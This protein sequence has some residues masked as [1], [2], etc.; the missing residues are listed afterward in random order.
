MR[1][2]RGRRG[3]PYLFLALLMAISMI[4]SSGPA[5]AEDNEITLDT[6]MGGYK[7][8]VMDFRTGTFH[9]MD[10][11]IP[12]NIT[13]LE[14]E[15]NL[16][17]L[18]GDIPDEE[19]MDFSTHSVGS[20]I[21]ASEKA[22]TG[23]FPPSVDPYNNTWTR[24]NSTNVANIKD[25]DGTYWYTRT[26]NQ[27]AGAPYEFPVQ[28]YHFQ[29]EDVANV[30][31]VDVV[32]NGIG[33]CRTNGTFRYQ[34]G[35]YMYS[36]SLGAWLETQGCGGTWSTDYWMNYTLESDS[37]FIS[38]NGSIDVAIIGPPA[39]KNATAW[40]YGHLRTDYIGLIVKVPSGNT[41]YPEDVV[42]RV[43]DKLTYS[44]AGTFTGSVVVGDAQGLKGT[45]QDHIDRQ[46]GWTNDTI[47][48][49]RVEVGAKTCGK[50]NVSGL[51]IVYTTDGSVIPNLPPRW[52]GPEQV[53]VEEDC[54]WTPVVDLDE[55]FLD[56]HDQGGLVFSVE[57]VN[58]TWL[59]TRVGWTVGGNRTLEVNPAPDRWGDV[60]VT[61]SATDLDGAT[62]TSSPL[63]VHVAP[64]PDAPEIVVPGLL[65]AV[66]GVPFRMTV[67]VDDRDLPGDV[68]VFS[69]DSELFDVDPQNGTID[70]T[71]TPDDVGTH[72]CTITVTDFLGLTDS[73]QL[74]IRVDN[75]NDPPVITSAARIDADEGD[76]VVYQVLA[77]D[78]D[79]VHGDSLTYS[80]WS[81]HGDLEVDPLTGLVTLQLERGT[82]GEIKVLVTVQDR[83]GASAQLTLLV[84]VANVNDPPTIEPL[85]AQTHHEG[86]Q[87]SAR[88]IYDDPD[89]ALDLPVP[90]S[91]TLSTEGP[92][93]LGPDAQGW[94][95]FTAAQEHV[96]E[97]LVTYTVTDAAGLTA[98]TDVM[99]T[100]VNINDGPVITT[101]VPV[102]MAALEEEAF[103]YTME[104]DD[105]DGDSLSWSD[106]SDLFDIN[107]TSGVISFTPAQADVGAHSVTVT[108]SDGNGGSD[109]VSF[110][111]VVMNVNDA[112]VIGEVLPEDGTRYREGEM[113]R[114][115]AVATDPDGDKLSVYWREGDTELGTGTPFSTQSLS[116]GTHTITLVVSDGTE[117]AESTLQ[118]IIRAGDGVTD[119][120]DGISIFLILSLLLGIATAVLFIYM[121]MAG[122]KA[123]ERPLM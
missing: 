77:E 114:F 23:I 76:K 15:L 31:E 116:V 7:Y 21:W 53:M 115:S 56:D 27:P 100:I 101:Q 70:W 72:T 107:P 29:L 74:S 89:L 95:R 102:E 63:E 38:S 19:T 8:S 79:A 59:Q 9:I 106:D 37:M 33:E 122:R 71:P 96:G 88:I 92:D 68:L 81:L 40:D 47:I 30:T 42:L 84:E 93:W 52:D 4:L 32:W 61:L 51:R 43:D 104:A 2:S 35:S 6:F 83:E 49:F 90:E 120:D 103:T 44:K 18:A 64:V 36:H 58:A 123:P 110:A 26:P 62:G 75:V 54:G 121:M 91:L 5:L 113:V 60:R 28:I 16:T 57:S 3:L 65:T 99:W 85:G 1:F 86:N 41:E 20:D 94:I 39:N 12:T 13:V 98:F 111:L 112:P 10:I 50:V 105:E 55:A 17:G 25:D 34:A 97:Y 24:V 22:A 80:A 11:L 108:V 73:A 117:S 118:V 78:P 66:E 14:A 82:V 119:E 46:P 48:E 69:D 87:V 45:I 109:S 67:Q